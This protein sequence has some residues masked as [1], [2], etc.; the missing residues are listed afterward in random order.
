MK[1][2]IHRQKLDPFGREFV[3]IWLE[4]HQFDALSICRHRTE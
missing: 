3:A 1:S 4:Q 2:Y